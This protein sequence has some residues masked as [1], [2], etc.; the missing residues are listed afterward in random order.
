[1]FTYFGYVL[2]RLAH[3]FKYIYG[4]WQVNV[5]KITN[6][7]GVYSWILHLGHVLHHLRLELGVHRARLNHGQPVGL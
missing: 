3:G 5:F 6:C 1:M 4:G 7:V 2:W